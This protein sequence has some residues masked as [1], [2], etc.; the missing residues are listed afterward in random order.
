VAKE[1]QEQKIE[2]RTA[3]ERIAGFSML[4]SAVAL[5][6]MKRPQFRVELAGINTGNVFFCS[7]FGSRNSNARRRT[8]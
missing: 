7:S 4:A 2:T 5:L 8:S 3:V 6:F 1:Q